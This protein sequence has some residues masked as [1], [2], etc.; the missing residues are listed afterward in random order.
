[1]TVK[2]LV[3][4]EIGMPGLDPGIHVRESVPW[5][6][7]ITPI[8]AITARTVDCRVKPGNDEV[9]VDTSNFRHGPARTWPSTSRHRRAGG[10]AERRPPASV[11]AA[12]RRRMTLA[13]PPYD[14]RRA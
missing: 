5:Y 2:G 10:R 14:A 7:G 1:M 13:L 11:G 4:K 12:Q 8:G 6:S 3:E 9:V